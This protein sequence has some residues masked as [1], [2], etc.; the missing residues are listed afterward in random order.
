MFE[1]SR[2]RVDS[3]GTHEQPAGCPALQRAKREQRETE[4]HAQHERETGRAVDSAYESRARIACILNRVKRPSVVLSDEERRT[5]TKLAGDPKLEAAHSR[6]VRVILLSA[7]GVAGAEIA[8]RLSLSP[9]Q[10]SRIRRRFAEH[11]VPGLAPRP[12]RGRR[13]HAVSPETTER[14]ILISASTPPPGRPR[15]SSRLIAARVGLT[16]ATVAKVLR[17]AQ[18]SKGSVTPSAAAGD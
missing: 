9:G 10:V 4:T 15:W 1:Q 17:R 16:S 12:H 13:D 6:R 7:D 14:I 8:Q 5:L 11:G 3:I 2:R 18:S